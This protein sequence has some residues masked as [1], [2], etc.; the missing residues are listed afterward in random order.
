[1]IQSQHDPTISRLYEKTMFLHRLNGL[2]ITND[3]DR[4]QFLLQREQLCQLELDFTQSI[5][6][7]TD[8]IICTGQ[9]LEGCPERYIQS[10]PRAEGP[11]SGYIVST[12]TP[13]YVTVMQSAKSD[14][15]RQRMY[16]AYNNRCSTSTK[17]QSSNVTRLAQMVV[18]RASLAK[19]LGYASHAHVKLEG[20]MAKTPDNLSF[21]SDLAQQL[22]SKRDGDLRRLLDVKQKLS[23]DSRDKVEAWDIPYLMTQLK[24][25]DYDLDDEVVSQYFPLEH[26][27]NGILKI[28][29]DLFGLVFMKDDTLPR[30]HEDV[31]AYSVTKV[32]T[33][34]STSPV[35]GYFY[36]D[37]HPR[38][39]K[40]GHQ[41]VAPLEPATLNG[42]SEGRPT[43]PI[44]AN[45]GN[46]TKPTG[47][48]PSLLKFSEVRTFFH[49]FGHVVHCLLTKSQWSLF[50]WS[51]SLNPY[52]GGVEVDFLELPSQMFENWLYDGRV[53]DQL[54]CHY[55]SRSQLPSQIKKTLSDLRTLCNGYAYTRQLFMSLFDLQI[56][57]PGFVPETLLDALNDH[58]DVRSL[59]LSEVESKLSMVWAQLQKSINGTSMVA[60]T[61][62]F[63]SWYHLAGYDATYYSYIYSEVFSFDC[64]DQFKKAAGGCYNQEVA[65]KYARTILE[66]GANTD[67]DEM[68]RNFLNRDPSNEAFL[69]H[70]LGSRK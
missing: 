55:Q 68:L 69:N 53:L 41:C 35:I 6:E 14:T 61:Y 32:D 27:L 37:L 33:L 31:R 11:G 19:T 1:L 12:K 10:L 60:K 57:S 30:W 40:Y 50:S 65:G 18:L 24:K 56:H 70:V 49:E 5:N 8:F 22:Q 58:S 15:V 17:D 38:A 63:A 2:T 43:L 9:E 44:A 20:N 23:N 42:G 39:G 36:L 64:F 7:C 3:Q 59:D 66:P 25:Q 26:V 21:L 51:W 47:S 52:P 48:S 16:M 28:Y 54:S 46:L 4:K 62:P 29:S 13:D 34:A 67:G 45:I